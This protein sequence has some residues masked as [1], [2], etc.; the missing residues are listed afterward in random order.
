MV[1]T[2]HMTLLFWQTQSMR[3]CL[4]TG[5]I[6]ALLGTLLCSLRFQIE[7]ATPINIDT[8]ITDGVSRSVTAGRAH[9]ADLG[10]R[11]IEGLANDRS[12]AHGASPVQEVCVE[13][14]DH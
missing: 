4:S 7:R 14:I 10:G 9:V 12:R 11:A 5:H 3:H 6:C 1:C 13:F 8:R 2:V